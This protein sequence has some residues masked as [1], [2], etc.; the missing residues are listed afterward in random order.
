MDDDVIRVSGKQHT[1]MDYPHPFI[2]HVVKENIGQQGTEA[3]RP[4]IF[5][6]MGR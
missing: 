3:T 6:Y 5:S 1:R 2:K 4:A